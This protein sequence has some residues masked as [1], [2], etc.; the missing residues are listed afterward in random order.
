MEGT[1]SGC[2]QGVMR[3]NRLTL[4]SRILTLRE[5]LMK[6]HNILKVRLRQ[7]Q[8]TESQPDELRICK[9]DAVIV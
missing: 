2:M 4:R 6:R 1:R 3:V 9:T 7:E 8:E 5:V